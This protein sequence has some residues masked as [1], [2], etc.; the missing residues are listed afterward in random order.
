MNKLLLSTIA[1]LSL[2]S[3][4]ACTSSEGAFHRMSEEE[5][6]AYN[7]TVAGIDQIYCVEEVRAGSHIRRRFCASV[8]E[9]NQALE[10]QASNLDVIN[11]GPPNSRIAT[12]GYNN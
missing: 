7:A 4:A 6:A 8:G 2:L 12:P 11:Y 5:L 3:L 9:I 1:T 10:N